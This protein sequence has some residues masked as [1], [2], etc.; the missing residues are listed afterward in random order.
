MDTELATIF[1]D[2]TA[3]FVNIQSPSPSID[4]TDF[5][6]DSSLV[7]TFSS[8]PSFYV[9]APISEHGYFEIQFM[10]ANNFW[11][12]N[13]SFGNDSNG[14]Q[15]RQGIAHLIDKSAFASREPFIAGT[16]TAIDNPVPPNNGGLPG[17]NPCNWDQS[18]LV[19]N[20]N[21][22]VGAPGG[23]AYHLSAAAGVNFPWQPALGSNDFCAAAQ[24]FVNAGVASGFA[25]ST[26]VLTGISANAALHTVNFFVRSDDPA[27]L[28][29]GQSMSQEICALFTGT[30]STQCSP[31]LTEHEAPITAF[32]GFQTSQTSVKKDWWIYTAGYIAVYP[33]DQ[34]LYLTYHSIFVSGIS[35]IIAPSG[36]CSSGSVPSSSAPDY[37]YICNPGYDILAAQMEFAPCLSAP[38]DP[39]LGQSAPTFA[40]CP[41]STSLTAISAGY[42]AEDKFGQNALTIPVFS[43]SDQYGYLHNW[44]RVI[45]DDGLGSPNIFTWLN[46]YSPNPTIPGTIRQGF[47]QST[48]S[49]S[50]Y[51]ASTAWDF[52]IM[53]NIF[54]TLTVQN[55]LSHGQLIDWTTVSSKQLPNSL[56]TYTPPTGTVS[57]FRFTL[58]SDIYWQDGQKMTSWDAKFSY[59]TL[60]SSGAF[61]C[62]PCST[63]TGVTVLS[64]AQFDI[65]LNAVGPFTKQSLTSIT[66]F[67][68]HLWSVC[69]G[70]IWNNYATSGNV[71]DSCISTDP[72]KL[73]AAFDPLA[74]GILIGSGPWQCGS[75]KTVGSGCS[76][77][78]ISNP[79]IGGSYILT[80]YGKGFPANSPPFDVYFRSM[81]NLALYIWTG[82]TGQFASDFV[83]FTTM[84]ACFN[85]PV[86]T[87]APCAHFQNGIGSSNG[88]AGPAAP[89]GIN[90]VLAVNRFVGVNWVSPFNWN[91]AGPTGITPLPP[92][93]YEGGV[94]LNP[95]KIDPIH[96]YDC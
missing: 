20:T 62:G 51:L 78:G 34:T 83:N 18:F 94:T 91:I 52:Y 64:S 6:L 58:R 54:D 35:S 71:P 59:L 65:N 79:P 73:A 37:M 88:T 9:T 2:E 85:L 47:K 28:D 26:C 75:S 43:T 95:C 15:I 31:Y 77:T 80:R 50:P 56:L 33:F 5:R 72:A 53:N 40:T 42:K 57:T 3:E 39:A 87:A 21:C 11:G 89:V 67:P 10:M 61:Q 7:S 41:G 23:T 27:R 13:F 30:F 49:L 76:S 14:L 45:N 22:T 96:G 90:Q 84:A 44:Q 16:A 8:S 86:T 68:G 4:L 19:S 93:L 81:G 69:A 25:P 92:V 29:L 48:S 12:V 63:I 55:P 24:H 60:K 32:T 74:A 17:A 38:G 46:S 1:T 66:L 36:L 70:A 82:D